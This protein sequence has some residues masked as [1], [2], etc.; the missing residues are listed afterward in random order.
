MEQVNGC[1]E[2]ICL[3]FS[4]HFCVIFCNALTGQRLRFLPAPM[5]PTFLHSVAKLNR[6]LGI[7]K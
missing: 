3:H 7:K 6:V 2:C 5:R 1:V 4:A